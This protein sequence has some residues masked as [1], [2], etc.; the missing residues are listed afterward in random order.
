MRRTARPAP[1]GGFTL[2]ELLVVIAIMA[3]L[4]ALVAAGVGQ[5]RTAQMSKTTDQ[6]LL[7]LQQGLAKQ[8]SL[9][10]EQAR[11]LKNDVPGPL[12]AIADG[13]VER[14]RSLYAYLKMKQEFPQTFAEAAQP[15]HTLSDAAATTTY[16]L[17]RLKVFANIPAATTLSAEEQGAA[18]LYLILSQKGK[19]GVSSP[20]EDMTNGVQGEVGGFTIIKDAWGTPITFVRF[21]APAEIQSPPYAKAGAT[22]RDP[23]DIAPPSNMPTGRLAFEDPAPTGVWK[24]S[25]NKG[26]VLTGLNQNAGASQVA[27]DGSNKMITPVSAGPDREFQG[28]GAADTDDRYGFWQ[29]RQGN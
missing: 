18:L 27:F 3:L 1:R 4:A 20:I 29:N 2:V 6:T 26:T 22:A 15:V 12:V 23:L 14:G 13:D 9:V 17:P 10:A 8:A 5:V 16:S 19:G 25:R 11:N 28:M 21:A 24:T 7:K